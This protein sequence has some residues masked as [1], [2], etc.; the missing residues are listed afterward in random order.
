MDQ[1]AVFTYRDK[2]GSTL[3]TRLIEA[4]EKGQ[5]SE[6]EGTLIAGYLQDRIGQIETDEELTLL[7][8]EMAEKWEIFQ[9]IFVPSGDTP[10]E[11]TT[12]QPDLALQEQAQQDEDQAQINKA[13]E[14]LTAIQQSQPQEG[15]TP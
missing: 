1:N 12:Q 6:E 13:E 9:E 10:Q 11:A 2:V 3:T 8:T 4:L 5:I 7:L 15:A 14:A